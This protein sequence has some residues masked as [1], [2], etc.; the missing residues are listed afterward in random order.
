MIYFQVLDVATEEQ[1]ETQKTEVPNK[2]NE[3]AEKPT[4]SSDD[5]PIEQENK[6]EDHAQ[7]VDI[8]NVEGNKDK[9]K[10]RQHPEGTF[11][12]PFEMFHYL[13]FFFR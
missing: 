6:V 2:E 7:A 8:K 11:L 12:K 9:T 3:E 10:K 13:S 4:E 1:I 5:L